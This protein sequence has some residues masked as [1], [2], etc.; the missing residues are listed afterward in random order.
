MNHISSHVI[1]LFF[2]FSF[3][4]L[5]FSSPYFQKKKKKKT[6]LLPISSHI[7]CYI[8]SNF[9]LSFLLFYLPTTLLL[10]FLTLFYNLPLLSSN[11]FLS[12]LP[13]YFPT[14][15]SLYFLSLFYNLPLLLPIL[16]CINLISFSH[17]IHIFPTQNCE[18]SVSLSLSLLSFGEFLFFLITLIKVDGFFFFLICVLVLYSF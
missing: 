4:Y 10:Y 7:Y 6:F 18:Y 8:S 16:F 17:S 9:S 3:L 15:F 1:Y 11:L 13:L 14:T 2:I 12:F 5:K